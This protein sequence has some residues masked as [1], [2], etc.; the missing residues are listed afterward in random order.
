MFEVNLFDQHGRR[1]FECFQIVVITLAIPVNLKVLSFL[2]GF[3][4]ESV[5]VPLQMAAR[6]HVA[7]VGW[8]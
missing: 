8:E 2:G 1:F 3:L 4:C 5:G 6:G 7:V